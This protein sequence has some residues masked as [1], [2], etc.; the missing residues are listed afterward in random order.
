MGSKRIALGLS[1]Y[2]SPAPVPQCEGPLL[3]SYVSNRKKS[4][5][6]TS[7]AIPLLVAIFSLQFAANSAARRCRELALNRLK[8]HDN[9]S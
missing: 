2:L 6:Y 4:D 3:P 7:A 8:T 1:S 5:R 9:F